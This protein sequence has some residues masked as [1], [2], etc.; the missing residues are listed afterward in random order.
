MAIHPIQSFT[1]GD[2]FKVKITHNPAVDVGSAVFKV[3]LSKAETSTPELLITHI[4]PTNTDS[5]NGI[6]YIPF[7]STDTN[8]VPP[9]DYYISIRRILAG[10]TSTILRTNRYNVGKVTC[11]KKIDTPT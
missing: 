7:T 11:F 1:Q 5:G 10:E 2:S 8:S 6:I 3:A 4:A 9:G